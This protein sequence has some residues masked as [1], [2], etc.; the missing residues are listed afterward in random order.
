LEGKAD[1]AE[2]KMQEV[3]GRVL[4]LFGIPAEAVGNRSCLAADIFL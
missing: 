4:E 1:M 3:E 2:V